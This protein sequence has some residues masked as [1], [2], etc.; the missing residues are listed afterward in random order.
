MAGGASLHPTAT[1]FVVGVDLGQAQDFTAVVVNERCA[2]CPAQP[3]CRNPADQLA[4]LGLG[5]LEAMRMMLEGM[6]AMG[7]TEVV[8][9]RLTLLHRFPLGTPYPAIVEGLR[10]LLWQLPPR[11]REPELV[12]DATGVGRP[13]LDAMRERGLRPIG[14]TITGGTDVNKRAPDDW[15]VPKRILASRLQVVLQSERIKIAAEMPLTPLLVR[16]LEAFRAK[17]SIGGNETFEAWREQDHDD[18]VLAAAMAVW[19]AEDLEQRSYDTSLK[20]VAG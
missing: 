2:H 17:I 12:V 18:L 3:S 20:W 14:V 9:H 8:H 19:G 4:A 1:G 11:E 13:V 6:A 15:R 16:E 5:A 7:G 10:R